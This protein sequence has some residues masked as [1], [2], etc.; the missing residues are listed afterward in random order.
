MFSFVF[1]RF[2]NIN[3]QVILKYLKYLR[4][5]S[6]EQERFYGAKR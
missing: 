1:K 5:V 3:T 2:I 4:G 6:H